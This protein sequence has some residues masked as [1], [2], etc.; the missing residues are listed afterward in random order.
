MFVL[1][2]SASIKAFSRCRICQPRFP[3]HPLSSEV[4]IQAAS[5]VT[6]IRI[7]YRGVIVLRLVHAGRNGPHSH[8]LSRERTHQI[9]R[10]R[11]LAKPSRVII[12]R[13]N[14]RHPVMNVGHELVGIRRETQARRTALIDASTRNH[15]RSCFKPPRRH[16]QS[17]IT[18]PRGVCKWLA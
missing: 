11:L 5:V 14:N 13:E 18:R 4:S 7:E 16:N 9:T 6:W 17:W 3:A 1:I 2:S 10:I 15:Y 8:Q 12:S